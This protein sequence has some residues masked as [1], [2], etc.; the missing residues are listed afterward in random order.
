[1]QTISRWPPAPLKSI[2]HAHEIT[3][4]FIYFEA[5]NIFI[6]SRIFFKNLFDLFLVL[7]HL[8]NIFN[9][10][11]NQPFSILWC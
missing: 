5:K 9:L 6:S 10:F 1:M 3:C 4:L 8:Y 11:D 7:K 2:L